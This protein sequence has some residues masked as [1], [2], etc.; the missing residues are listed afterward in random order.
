MKRYRQLMLIPTPE[1]CNWSK[2]D[3]TIAR[4]HYH[5]N[6]PNGLGGG[7]NQYRVVRFEFS[8][9]I[10]FNFMFRENFQKRLCKYFCV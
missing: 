4:T 1:N 8:T 10:L 9:D 5:R 2:L 3:P 7:I 6:A